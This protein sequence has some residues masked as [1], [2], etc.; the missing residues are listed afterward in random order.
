[1]AT[2]PSSIAPC[3]AKAPIWAVTP[4]GRRF[5]ALLNAW[6]EHITAER[7]LAWTEPTDPR[8]GRAQARVEEALPGF[9][10]A[11]LAM[12]EATPSD[13]LDEPLRRMVLLVARLVRENRA[14]AFTRYE[15]LAG[16]LAPFFVVPGESPAVAEVR[17]MLVA[18]ERRIALMARLSRSRAEGAALEAELLAA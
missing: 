15:T 18:A 16:D 10:D 8:H 7:I 12:T 3:A 9:H 5:I 1:M 4:Y 13:P 6:G 11:L 17:K 2:E 14:S